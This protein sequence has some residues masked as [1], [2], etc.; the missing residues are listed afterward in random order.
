MFALDVQDA[1]LFLVATTNCELHLVEAGEVELNRLFTIDK[2][3]SI[4]ETRFQPCIRVMLFQVQAT[5][6]ERS[7]NW[8]M[9][10]ASSLPLTR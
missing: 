5:L 8:L 9:Q 7:R 10:V 3:R 4:G 6:K 1:D 2:T